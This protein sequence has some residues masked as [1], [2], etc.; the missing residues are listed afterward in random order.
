MHMMERLMGP[1]DAHWVT[2]I[3]RHCHPQSHLVSPWCNVYFTDEEM[4]AQQLENLSKT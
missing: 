3:C 2:T 4:D 1:N